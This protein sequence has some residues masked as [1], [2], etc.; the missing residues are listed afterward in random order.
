MSVGR[1]HNS[2]NSD[3]SMLTESDSDLFNKS[4]DTKLSITQQDE[5][6][7]PRESEI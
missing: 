1:Q 2:E 6:T 3:Y 4:N 5:Q 7:T